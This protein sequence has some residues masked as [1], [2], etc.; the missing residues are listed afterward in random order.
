MREKG[1]V[2]GACSEVGVGEGNDDIQR[3]F[4]RPTE[5][6]T[7]STQLINRW[8]TAAGKEKSK[9]VSQGGV[10]CRYGERSG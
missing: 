3:R 1:W 7:E 2:E 10:S 8:G 9:A 6:C 4:N 5:P